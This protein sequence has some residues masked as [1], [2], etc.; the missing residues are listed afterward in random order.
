MQIIIIFFTII[1]SL[2]KYKLLKVAFL[3][4]GQGSQEVRMGEGL[5]ENYNSPYQIV[6]SGKSV[7]INKL[8]IL[9]EEEE[10]VN[11]VPLKV[12]APFYLLGFNSPQLC[13]DQ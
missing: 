7:I 10:E 13:C 9:G 4:P 11:I 2:R 3:F 12:S 1:I 5:I 8:L 6:V